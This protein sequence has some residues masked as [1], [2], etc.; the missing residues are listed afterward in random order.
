[1]ISNVICSWDAVRGMTHEGHAMDAT[2]DS[3]AVDFG[4]DG[5][6]ADGGGGDG[7][8]A[9]DS[10]D[11]D[12]GGMEYGSDEDMDYAHQGDR[13]LSF[14]TAYSGGVHPRAQSNLT[15]P[16]QEAQ[17]NMT[18]PTP[19]S[20]R[21]PVPLSTYTN[22]HT[23]SPLGSY[24]NT[25]SPLGVFGSQSG[26]AFH[27]HVPTTT[28]T[29]YSRTS[30]RGIRRGDGS[31]AQSNRT[32]PSQ[33]AQ[34]N[35]TAPGQMRSPCA[36]NSTDQADNSPHRSDSVASRRAD[37][38]SGR[39]SSVP[40]RLISGSAVRSPEAS[41]Y[42]NSLGTCS[43]R[44]RGSGSSEVVEVLVVCNRNQLPPPPSSSLPPTKL[45]S[46]HSHTRSLIH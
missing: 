19:A 6:D 5:G 46:T 12:D 40:P 15:A 4:A 21:G 29:S 14:V 7:G 11:G 1:M 35:R 17:S 43:D 13:S 26:S 3:A 24:T 33:M 9:T 36:D 25:P 30:V 18:A 8:V 39:A 2:D 44:C 31:P 41:R 32:A 28:S 34:S 16:S 45:L 10:G 23:P 42:S 22:T 37:S 20:R 38:S 27:A